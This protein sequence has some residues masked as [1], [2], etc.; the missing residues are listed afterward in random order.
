MIARPP[1][2]E[3]RTPS[4]AT[5]RGLSIVEVTMA[6]LILSVAVAGLLKI[7]TVAASQRRATE[8]R[9]LALEEIA[10]QAEQIALLPWEELTAEKLAARQP[11][12][13]LL[14]A[15]RSAQLTLTASEDAG[16]PAAKRIRIAVSWT[17]PT[18][19]SAE[20]VQL[21]IWRHP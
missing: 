19:E 1:N 12:A 3:P 21:T 20:P 17:T 14:A 6:L 9:R 16:P 13:D 18:G 5:R 15:A 2:P 11:S 4:P 8:N 10:N 7:L